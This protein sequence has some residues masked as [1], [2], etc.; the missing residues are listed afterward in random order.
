MPHILVVD[1]DELI[2]NL[3]ENILERA[4]YRVSLAEDGPSLRAV[5]EQETVDLVLLDIRLGQDHG[6]DLARDVTERFHTPIIFVTGDRDVTDKVTGLEIGAE[7]YI[8]KPFDQRE[9][10]GPDPGGAAP[11]PG[12]RRGRRSKTAVRRLRPASGR[13]RTA[14]TR[15]W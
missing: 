14:R 1:D 2:R 10:A 11:P 12:G 7:D 9:A 3:L 5:L 8:T 13:P 15:R 4:G 6:F